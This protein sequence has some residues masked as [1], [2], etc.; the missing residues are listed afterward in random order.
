MKDT[1]FGLS[2]EVI[3]CPEGSELRIRNNLIKKEW[4]V[5]NEY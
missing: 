4:A 3:T 1:G 5:E 2:I